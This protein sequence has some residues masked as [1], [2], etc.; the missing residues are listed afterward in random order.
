MKPMSENELLINQQA[1]T[2]AAS[3]L[4]EPVGPQHDASK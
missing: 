3:V 2:V 4:S 1:A